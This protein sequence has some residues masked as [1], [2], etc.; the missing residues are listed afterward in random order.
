MYAGAMTGVGVVRLGIAVVQLCMG[1]SA[2]FWSEKFVNPALKRREPPEVRM[3][4]WRFIGYGFIAL[5]TAQVIAV[6]A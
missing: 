4:R 5:G 3:R 1:L 2:A 6:L